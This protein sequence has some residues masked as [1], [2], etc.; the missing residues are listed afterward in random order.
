[1]W[2]LECVTFVNRQQP[3]Q[4]M[5]LHLA[6]FRIL[7]ARSTWHTPDPS[8]CIALLIIRKVISDPD[9]CGRLKDGYFRGYTRKTAF[10]ACFIRVVFV[11]LLGMNFGVCGALLYFP[12]HL[13]WEHANSWTSLWDV[14]FVA[15][16]Y[17][18][19]CIFQ[20]HQLV[21]RVSVFQVTLSCHGT[22]RGAWCSCLQKLLRICSH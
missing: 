12:E 6:C 22:A 3:Q 10:R 17:F 11:L 15:N 18:K 5:D 9:A 7:L 20:E 8:D 16:L 1:M 14:C 4:W 19:A 13:M 21:M 2:F